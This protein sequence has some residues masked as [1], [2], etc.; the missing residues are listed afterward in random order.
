MRMLC[1]MV[2][3]LLTWPAQGGPRRIEGKGFSFPVPRGYEDIG[4]ELRP[5]QV[6][7]DAV[8]V[9]ARTRTKGFR[10]TITLQ[11]GKVRVRTGDV[12]SCGETGRMIASGVKGRLKEA[13]MVATGA[14]R[15]CQ[16][17]VVAPEGVALITELNGP[18]Q[19]WLMTCNHAVG[20]GEAGKV[21]RATL[22]GFRFKK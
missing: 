22:A 11:R 10:P 21:C 15:S 6:A 18:D 12:A 2:V 1:G 14:G 20:D 4:G 8:A 5:D 17:V 3:L 7:A 19:T 9:G 13:A 16:M